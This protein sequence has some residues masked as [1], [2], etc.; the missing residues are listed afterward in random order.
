[1]RTFNAG[2]TNGIPNGYGDLVNYYGALSQ[3]TSTANLSLGATMIQDEHKKL[4]Q[5][6]FF[7]E[8]SFTINTIAK[9]QFYP[10][11]YNYSKLKTGTITNGNLTWTP[12]EILSR[13]EWD[14]LNT[15]KN[16]AGNIPNNYYIWGNKI[17]FWP[18]PSSATEVITFNYQIRVPDLTLTDYV[19]GTVA[20]T[21][22]GGVTGTTNLFGGSATYTTNTAVATTG[23]NGS[24]CTVD[25]T[26]VAGVIT[27]I[28]VN[29][30]G[31]GYQIG[32]TLTISGGD[33]TA[34]FTVISISQ[35]SV[36]TGTTTAWLTTPNFIAT[37][38]SVLNLNLWIRITAPLGDNNWY[39]ISSID[40]ATQLTLVNP[41]QGATCTVAS[42]VIGQLPLLLEDF[43][44]IPVYKPLVIYFSTINLNEAK[45]AEFKQLYKEGIERL[46]KYCGTKSLNVNLSRPRVGP[47]PNL[48]QGNFG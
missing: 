12:T 46:D 47:N 45:K 26:A 18:I 28:V 15:Q 30:A 31:T 13:R 38:G 11:P 48:F 4:L 21:N 2:T 20:A 25:I 32:D 43:Q 33:G 17:G 9:Q 14:L 22:T 19:I 34:N 1:M 42:Y 44:D 37:A 27:A 35:S 23:G 7:N 8:S 39:K 40:S 10:L 36:I 24:G 41:Y 29:A 6:Y 5:E 16:Y 3:N